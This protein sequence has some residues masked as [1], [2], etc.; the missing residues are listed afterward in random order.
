M[1]KGWIYKSGDWNIL[2]DVC[3]LKTKASKTKERWDGFRVCPSCFEQRH[4]M[5]YIK[6]RADKISV[7]FTRPQPT[8]QF[9]DASYV[10][11][12][13]DDG[14]YEIEGAGAGKQTYF[15]ETL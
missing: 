7:P 12:Y 1:S 4:P 13:I 9:A 11:I 10:T 6:A 15:E 3:A 2:C 14:Y 5:D 8:D